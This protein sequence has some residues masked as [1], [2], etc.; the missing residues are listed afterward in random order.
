MGVGALLSSMDY[1]LT[2][3]TFV[4]I[5]RQR[6]VILDLKQDRY[7]QMRLEDSNRLAGHILGWPV[8][9]PPAPLPYGMGS[10]Y[11]VGSEA[12]PGKST[13]RSA[14]EAEAGTEVGRGLTDLV[15]LGLIS[16]RTEP[17]AQVDP[18]VAAAKV[19]LPPAQYDLLSS[20]DALPPQS[21]RALFRCYKAGQLAR[22]WLRTLP[23]HEVVERVR[24]LRDRNG[25]SDSILN[26]PLAWHVVRSFHYLR[27]FLR[28][29][30][31][32]CLLESLSLLTA[33][34]SYRLH[35]HW[36][37][38]VRTEPFFAH[39]WLQELDCVLNDSVDHVRQFTPIMVV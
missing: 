25:N 28:S 16:T 9:N 31:D 32:A 27:P 30:K 4:C 15:R 34:G 3:H 20:G 14:S 24:V 23:L 10:A 11:G 21:W 37:F 13:A 22:R 6:T 12:S 38:G 5:D 8:L 33:L 1:A 7:M 35:A 39:C 18:G 26:V 36:V 2:P 17:A 19:V 29:S